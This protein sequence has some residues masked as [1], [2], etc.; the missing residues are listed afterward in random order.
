[1]QESFKE[2]VD[3]IYEYDEE[4]P[5]FARKAFN[6]IEN[7]N[8]EGA[9]KILRK[10]IELY[11]SFPVAYFILGKA[12]KIAGEYQLAEDA[13]RKGSEMIRSDKSLNF[14]LNELEK[15]K[16]DRI[17]FE[18][19]GR[20]DVF[21]AKERETRKL[22]D[23]AISFPNDDIFEQK[24]KFNV[25]EQLEELAQK[26]SK[27]KKPEL[28]KDAELKEFKPLTEE[29]KIVSETMANIYLNQGEFKEAV[30]VYEQLIKEKPAKKDYYKRRIKEIKEQLDMGEE[31]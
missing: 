6:E 13:F 9:V 23:E 2:K 25:D 24:E 16:R 7:N 14:Y 11:P 3:L 12:Y 15:N 10:G 20:G 29:K 30:K 26:L 8:S 27:A 28:N 21:Y 1:M 19:R 5:L 18:G 22:V 31:W 17:L 4:T